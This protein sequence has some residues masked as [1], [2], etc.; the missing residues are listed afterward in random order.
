MVHSRMEKRQDDILAQIPHSQVPEADLSNSRTLDEISSTHSHM[1]R[2]YKQIT[3]V[4]SE[5]MYM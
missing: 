2:V 1:F 3:A 5:S 4:L